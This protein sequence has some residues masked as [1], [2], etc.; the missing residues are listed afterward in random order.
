MVLKISSYS[1]LIGRCSPIPKL[2]VF[3]WM[4]CHLED[5]V[6]PMM[7]MVVSHVLESLDF[8]PGND[9]L[10][11]VPYSLFKNSWRLK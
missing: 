5:L 3:Q 9:S 4:K 10:H 8:E 2:G 11:S 6:M 1:S 7:D